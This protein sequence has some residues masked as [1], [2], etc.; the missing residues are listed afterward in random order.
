M[1][2]LVI[3]QFAHVVLGVADLA[4]VMAQ[5]R[6]TAAGHPSDIETELSSAYLGADL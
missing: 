4:V 3:E 1:S 6:I 5:G 2:I